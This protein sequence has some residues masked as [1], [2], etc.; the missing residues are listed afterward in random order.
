MLHVLSGKELCSGQR[1]SFWCCHRL[2]MCRLFSNYT[3]QEQ[4]LPH[5]TCP[6]K[7]VKKLEKLKQKKM[8]K[9]VHQR[10]SKPKGPLLISCKRKAYNFHQGQRFNDHDVHSLVSSGWKNSKRVGDYFT[11]MSH[12]ENPSLQTASEPISFSDLG[13]SEA[14]CSGLEELGFQ[15]PTEIQR[16]AIPSLLQGNNVTCAAETGSG[17]TLAYLLPSIEWILKSK[18][19]LK[20]SELGNV[21]C[22]NTIIMTPNRELCSQVMG[23]AESL[24]PYADFVPHCSLGSHSPSGPTRKR[25]VAPMDV[26][27]TSPGTLINLLHRN[28]IQARNLQHIVI[29]ESD[30]LLDDSFMA[31]LNEIFSRLQI[32][33]AEQVAEDSSILLGTQLVLVSAT[34]PRNV[35]QVLGSIVP[36]D[37]MHKITTEALHHIMPHVPQKFIRINPDSK[38]EKLIQLLKRGMEK[39]QP[40]LVFVKNNKTCYYVAKLLEETGLDCLRLSGDMPVEARNGVL[41]K[42]MEGYSDVLIATDVASR[43]LDTVNVCHV[44]NYDFP[45]FMSDYIHRVGRVGRIGTARNAHVTS[46]VAHKWDVDLVWKIEI[47][48]RK[49]KGLSDVN[50]NIKRELDKL[51]MHKDTFEMNLI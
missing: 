10:R 27:V 44:I 13:I 39:R 12:S 20:Q 23:V 4:T 41:E 26:L 37:A 34:M 36:V 40:A 43:G 11:L 9:Q 50:A 16:L 18:E 35:G 3:N 31:D 14:L 25:M 22:P 7:M 51:K 28:T 2:L 33:P 49:M 46:F 30:T 21:N 24:T 8:N 42:F 6:Q 19:S 29:D 1:V 45:Q 17:K 48:A 15:N 32:M 5:V 38:P 47:S